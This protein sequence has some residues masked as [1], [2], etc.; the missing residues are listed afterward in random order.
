MKRLMMTI[1]KT[2]GAGFASAF[3]FSVFNILIDWL[4]H[5]PEVFSAILHLKAL[6]SNWSRYKLMSLVWADYWINWVT[7]NDWGNWEFLFFT[8]GSSFMLTTQLKPLFNVVI[9][10]Y[11]KNLYTFLQALL[12]AIFVLGVCIEIQTKLAIKSTY[13]GFCQAVRNEDYPL[14]YSYFSPEY[15]E[16]KNLDKFMNRLPEFRG[17]FCATAYGSE[18]AGTIRHRFNEVLLY[19]YSWTN[20]ACSFYIRSGPEV[21]LEKVNGRWYFTGEH[22][23]YVD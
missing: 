2:I 20:T 17:D 3:L 15:H 11:S 21:I 4:S 19:P 6:L 14:A 10:K 12:F 9:Q 5:C 13:T 16:R 23:W 22:V 7:S 8:F 18:F 1:F